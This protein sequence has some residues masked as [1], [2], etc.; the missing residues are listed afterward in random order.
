MTAAF[1]QPHGIVVAPTI[2][3]IPRARALAEL[4][5]SGRLPYVALVDCFQH[6]SS[7]DS[8]EETVVFDADIERPQ[9]SLHEIRRKE[10]IGVT[11]LQADDCYPEV[12]ALR[13][14]FPRVPHTNLR[15][16]EFPRSLCLYDQPW[17]HVTL[18]W[19]PTAFVERIRFWLAETAKGSLH[20]DDQP[21]E[22]LLVG[23]GYH[24]ILPADCF[25]GETGGIYQELK[26]SPAF[27]SKDCRAFI[28]EKG[29]AAEGLPY[30][31]L[32]FVA[33]PQMH[34]AIRHAPHSLRELHTFL[35][36]AGVA[37]IESLREKLADWNTDSLRNK[38]ILFVVA[39]PLT[40]TGAATVEST[41][42]W[43][44]L[45]MKSVADVGI[46]IGLWEESYHGLGLAIVPD[47]AAD[48][49]TIP[50]DIVSPHFDISRH[51]AAA[52]S[53]LEADERPSVAIGAGALGSQTLTLL[54]QSGFGAWCVIDEDILLP[55][56][57]ARHAL[58]CTAIGMPK[59][60]AV[61]MKLRKIYPEN[62]PLKYFESD[63]LHPGAQ[64][65]RIAEEL[66]SAELLLDLAASIPVSRYLAHEAPGTGRR[67]ALFLNPRGNDLVLLAED[68]ARAV[69]LD[70]LEMQ[71]YRAISQHPELHNHLT[72]PEGRLRYARSCRDVSST[73]PNHAVAMHAAIGAKGIRQALENDGA[74][75]YIWTSDPRTLN[76]RQ[77]AITPAQVQRNQHGPWTLVVDDYVQRRISELRQA[78]L[79]RE[80]GGVLLGAYDLDRK[81][82]YVVDTI[83][84]PPDSKEWP[85]LYIR[86]KKGLA[87]EVEKVCAITDGQL[88]YIGEWH[89]HPDN[90]VCTPSDDDL[91]VFEWLTQ[92]MADAGLPALMA[93]AGQGPIIAWYLGIM[94]R[95]G[96]WE[97]RL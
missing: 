40:R 70:C 11:F 16:A 27:S 54:A 88:E 50:L 9:Y 44:F 60:A 15:A 63:I 90:C 55:H 51:S 79:P 26:I 6:C 38:R 64:T 96:G 37:L 78:K 2:L 56:N 82:V 57:L 62:R 83:P 84:S 3:T 67:V 41:D 45:T 36:P 65:E 59:A 29:A 58:D 71:Y 18:R 92:N 24:I 12:V 4:I 72:P 81:I 76:V 43:V 48:G 33:E 21:L 19:T 32:S 7:T 97:V 95:A 10:R 23:N 46:A 42:L 69:A 20:E 77:V 5:C 1:L 22:P 47:P 39:F 68:E 89:S 80:T 30:V 53:G 61:A 13:P 17:S 8:A 93:I 75:I 66:R 86:G 31:A 49:S 35:K 14:D 74:A 28:A 25:K 87:G 91:Q 34:G 94:L 73:I 85:T 52:A